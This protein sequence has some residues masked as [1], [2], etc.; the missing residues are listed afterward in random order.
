MRAE[1]YW[2]TTTG[3]ARLA[4]MPKPRGGE[5]LEDAIRSLR[6]M[7]VDVLVST[8]TDEEILEEDVSLADEARYCENNRIE[9]LRFP[10]P[11]HT[12]PPLDEKLVKFIQELSARVASGKDIAIHCRAG[13]G[14]STTI[15][16][17]LM[18]SAGINPIRACEMISAARGF[19]VP[20][21]DDQ[22]NLIVRFADRSR[23]GQI[24]DEIN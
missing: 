19:T 22:R 8:L 21:T 6:E 11:D 18:V 4:T 23:D 16:A 24:A 9:F 20:E 3:S 17:C 12:A 7:G 14:R 1:I 5:W 13:L 15:A 2:V 10:V